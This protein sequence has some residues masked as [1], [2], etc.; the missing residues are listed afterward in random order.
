MAHFY[1]NNIL[2]T[3]SNRNLGSWKKGT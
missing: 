3:F 2:Y 1:I